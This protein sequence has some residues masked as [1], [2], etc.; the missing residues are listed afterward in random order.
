MVIWPTPSRKY[1]VNPGPPPPPPSVKICHV[2]A[3]IENS[4]NLFLMQNTSQSKWPR[5]HFG[6]PPFPPHGHFVNHLP[7]LWPRGIWMPPVTILISIFYQTTYVDRILSN[8]TPLPPTYVDTFTKLLLLSILCLLEQPPPLICSRGLYTSPNINV[9]IKIK[10]SKY[11]E[12][13]EM[14]SGFLIKPSTD[15]T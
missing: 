15:F 8:L 13:K 1:V 4:H 2:T 9:H 3:Q 5:D 11:M 7:L 6:N 12:W 14:I 10:V